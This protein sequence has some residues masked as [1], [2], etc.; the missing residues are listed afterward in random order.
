MKDEMKR[1]TMKDGYNSPFV[2]VDLI[3]MG[4]TKRRN[5]IH[6][7]YKRA[8]RRTMKHDLKNMVLD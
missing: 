1:R 2:E 4:H 8:A 3:Y 7:Q 6:Q 5:K